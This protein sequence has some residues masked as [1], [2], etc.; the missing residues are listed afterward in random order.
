MGEIQTEV[1]VP[2]NFEEEKDII[3]LEPTIMWC[4]TDK[5]DSMAESV[6][7]E[8]V[9]HI[10][11]EEPLPVLDDSVLLESLAFDLAGSKEECKIIPLPPKKRWWSLIE[12]MEPDQTPEPP[13]KRWRAAY[14]RSPDEAPCRCQQ[15]PQESQSSSRTSPLS[16]VDFDGNSGNAFTAEE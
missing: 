14:E 11:L 9:E 10:T 5:E 2:E 16:F 12:V 1:I 3:I 6:Q 15:P 8:V 4:P 13:K 7:K